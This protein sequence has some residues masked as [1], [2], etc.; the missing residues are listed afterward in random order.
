MNP[1][2]TIGRDELATRANVPAERV[3]ELAG[4]GLL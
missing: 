1:S 4:L 2:A 3:D